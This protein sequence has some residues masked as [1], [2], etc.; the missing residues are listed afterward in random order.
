MKL[1]EDLPTEIIDSDV[2]VLP[3][4]SSSSKKNRV[5]WSDEDNLE[6]LKQEIEKLKLEMKESTDTIIEL[7]NNMKM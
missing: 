1:E 7:Q 3:D 6:V 2:M 5:T 4:L